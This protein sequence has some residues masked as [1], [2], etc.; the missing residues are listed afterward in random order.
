MERRPL[1]S[2]IFERYLR[3]GSVRLPKQELDRDR[4]RSKRRISLSGRESGGRS[5]SRG[6]LYNLLSNPIYI[7]EIRHKH[8]S[9]PGQHVPIIEREVW[10]RAATQLRQRRGRLGVRSSGNAPSL[11]TGKLF[12]EH[13]EGLTPT[14]TKKGQ[15][16][17]RYYVSRSLLKG[18]GLDGWRI[19]AAELERL[20]V[21]AAKQILDDRGRLIKAIED[22][23][24]DATKIEK[25]LQ[26]ASAR[27]R[28]LQSGMDDKDLFRSMLERV[29]LRPTGV[30]VTLNLPLP[31]A[32]N[33]DA[34][35]SVTRELPLQVRRRGV[36]KRLLITDNALQEARIDRALLKA[37]ARAH[38]WLEDFVAGRATSMTLIATREGVSKRYVSRL[39]R[40]GLLAPE[41]VDGIAAGTQ[42][43]DLTAQALLTRDGELARSWH[44]QKQELGRPVQ[45]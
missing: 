18:V 31:T 11:L 35:I 21:A 24:L 26:L 28:Q 29:E 39:I 4:V 42:P 13:G 34:A 17:Y 3:L 8:T 30:R 2:A 12:D 37:V 27:S 44:A 32:T 9:Y 43:P 38:C 19:A 41:I 23:N 15:R 45:I 40:L 7:G 5:F 16:R 36:E 25:F 14:H 20:V 22:H 10:E 6:A 1:L 33:R